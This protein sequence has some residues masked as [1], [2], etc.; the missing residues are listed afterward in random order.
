MFYHNLSMH[1]C[2]KIEEIRCKPFYIKRLF[3]IARIEGS[4]KQN[5]Q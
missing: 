4:N 5:D 1:Y 3:F 2:E